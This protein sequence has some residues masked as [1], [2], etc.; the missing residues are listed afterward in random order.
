MDQAEALESWNNYLLEAPY[1]YCYWC[2]RSRHDQPRW[3]STR[4]IIERAHV[5]NKPRRL[6]RR[7]AI[8]LCSMCHMMEHGAEFD[9]STLRAPTLP[10]MLMCKW[11]FDRKYFDRASMQESYVGR[12][13]NRAR[14]LPS[15]VWSSH[16][17]FQLIRGTI[18]D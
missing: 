3:W 9:R 15:A 13:P 16:R 8:L 4:F 2:G 12:L 18:N 5:V 14:R 17:H 10:E 11:T 6:D 1:P 7:H